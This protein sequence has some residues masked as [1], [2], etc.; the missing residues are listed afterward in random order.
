MSCHTQ[1]IADNCD[2]TDK[3]LCK[4]SWKMLH[5]DDD[6]DDD[7]GKID[8]GLLSDSVHASYTWVYMYC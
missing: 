2:V 3:M 7:D 4:G 6:D 8:V 5:T 1:K